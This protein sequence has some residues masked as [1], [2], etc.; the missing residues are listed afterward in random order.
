MPVGS[1]RAPLAAGPPNLATLHG[2]PVLRPC[3][4]RENITASHQ[5]PKRALRRP[6]G[7]PR[8]RKTDPF[9]LM[10]VS[11]FMVRIAKK[12]MSPGAKPK[13]RIGG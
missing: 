3:Y 4:G 11:A 1:H 9:P 10:G 12:R 13:L 6:Q 2:A 7:Q 8:S 5:H